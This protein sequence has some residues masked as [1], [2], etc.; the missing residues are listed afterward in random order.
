[1]HISGRP[2]IKGTITITLYEDKAP[3]TVANFRKY[4]EDGYFN[5]TIFHRVIPGFVVQGGGFTGSMDQKQTEKPVRNEAENGLSNSTGTVA[6]AR[7]ADV[8]SATSQFFINLNDNTMLDHRDTT[9]R[10]Y[11]YCVFGTVTDGMDIVQQI[12]SV[13]TSTSGHHRD[14]PVRPVVITDTKIEDD[15]SSVV[16][17]IEQ[18]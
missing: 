7:T 10:G 17:T 11:G 3:E 2:A 5:N 4:A 12:A 18:K 6:M 15:G 8:H 16:L 1:M 9:P 14:V 13:E